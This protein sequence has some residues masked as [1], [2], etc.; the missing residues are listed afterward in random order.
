MSLSPRASKK[1]MNAGLY[2]ILMIGLVIIVFPLYI[3]VVTSM[4]TAAESSRSFFSL[5]GSF[6]MENF[7]SVIEKANFFIYV[8]NSFFITTFS[9]LGEI[10]LVPAFAY[11]VS[12]NKNK[13]F[14]KSVYLMTIIGLFIP[15][16]VVMLPTVKLFSRFE[17][18]NMGGVIL[19]YL[20][21]TLKKGVFLVVGYLDNISIEL[22]YSAYIDGCSRMQVYRLIVFP[23]LTPILATLL[24]VDGLW[25]WNDFLMPL[26]LL[27]ADSSS[28]TLPLFQAQFKN[29]YSFDFNLAFASFLLSMLPIIIFYMF[30]QKN[31]MSGITNGAI[32]G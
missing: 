27:N 12:R 2:F 21:Y 7:K 9:L 32:K 5:P 18:L 19:L 30:M 26:L 13:L 23:L 24:I 16:Q 14:F 22:E 15:F 17:L 31:I 20:T 28:W 10:I 11:A 8:R 3:T 4:K 1:L 6:Y 25:V 29:E